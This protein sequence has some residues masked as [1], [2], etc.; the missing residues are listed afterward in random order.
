[1][2]NTTKGQ[3]FEHLA[4]TYLIRNNYKVIKT[5]FHCKYG[6]LDIISTYFNEVIFIEVKS[7]IDTSDYS[8]YQTLTKQKL[9]KIDKTAQYWL[10][11]SK[12]ENS[13]YRIEFIGIISYPDKYYL[14]HF[15]YIQL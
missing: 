6:E 9:R 5:N 10:R 14:E 13:I 8:I 1:M 15:K 4:A 3:Y 11:Q 7:L 2:N 12:L